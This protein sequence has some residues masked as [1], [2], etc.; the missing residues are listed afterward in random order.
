MINFLNIAL[1]TAVCALT[2][3]TTSCKK[4]D[5]Y[6]TDISQRERIV[7]YLDG[8][9]QRYETFN[10]VYRQKLNLLPSIPGVRVNKGDSVWI[11]YAIYSFDTK[12]DSLITTNIAQLA[13]E[14][15][16]STDYLSL[17]PMG[18][19]Y[20]QGKV[21]K[22]WEAGMENSISG[23]SMMIFV[24]S[25]LAYGDKINGIVKKST[26]IAIFVAITNSKNNL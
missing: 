13:T 14:W 16:L 6:N 7:K 22:G 3:G 20:G 1:I 15:K 10:D 2:V 5:D 9:G 25:D 21:F 11:N 12:P 8:Q 18:M 24:P 4:E 17:V 23:D 19:V 26:T